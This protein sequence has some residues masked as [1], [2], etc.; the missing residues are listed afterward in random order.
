M[1]IFKT[2]IK[3]LKWILIALIAL[4]LAH[5]IYVII[6]HTVFNEKLPKVFG[7]ASAVVITGSMEDTIS[8]N[9][10]VLIHERDEYR[11]GDIITFFDQ[12]V[13]DY[14]THRII[15]VTDEG[16]LT[17]GDAN[18]APDPD[19]VKQEQVA[20]AVYCVLPQFGVVSSFISS[21]VGAIVTGA[22]GLGIIFLP[23]V[24]S[25]LIHKKKAE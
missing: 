11:E 20:G 14:V 3:I 21:P 5:N 23:D 18:N 17:K 10:V 7:F 24:I 13:N 19:P 15:S 16:Y 4:L 1:L 12:S 6:Q 25:S 2:V 8:P 9:D 22:I